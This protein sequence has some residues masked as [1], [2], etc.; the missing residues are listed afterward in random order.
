MSR[1]GDDHVARFRPRKVKLVGRED[2]AHCVVASLHDGARE[3]TAA[4][5]AREQRIV[6]QEDI[7]HEV[8][9]LDASY[10]QRDGVFVEVCHQLRIGQQGRARAFIAAPRVRRR[11]VHS[12]VGI[13]QAAIVAAEQVASLSLGKKAGERAPCFRKDKPHLVEEPLDLQRAAQENAAQDQSLDA[14]GM[15]LGIG[16]RECRAPRSAEDQPTLDA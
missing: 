10:G 13:G 11:H 3:M 1:V 4:V 16:K 6:G 5:D 15:R 7:V 14:I 2:R 12:R 8:M 9:R